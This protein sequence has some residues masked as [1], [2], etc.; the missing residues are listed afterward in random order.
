LDFKSL[1]YPSE[2]KDLTT[3]VEF[4]LSTMASDG[5]VLQDPTS[6]RNYLHKYSDLVLILLPIYM[7]VQERLGS[8]TQLTLQLYR[9]PEIEDEYLTL[10]ARTNNYDQA[11]IDKVMEISRQV[12]SLLT[13]AAGWLLVT[14]D[15]RP[16]Q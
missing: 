7:V 15:F 11:Y 8:E 5:V 3:E 4:L 13:D 1:F 9:D 16:P 6:I 10:Y 14:T 2:T 12:G